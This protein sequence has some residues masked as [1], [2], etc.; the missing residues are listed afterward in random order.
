ML[1]IVADKRCTQ[2]THARLLQDELCHCVNSTNASDVASR[3]KNCL[4]DAQKH[5]IFQCIHRRCANADL[6]TEWGAKKAG[7]RCDSSV[8]AESVR[9]LIEDAPR[10]KTLAP[11]D[12]TKK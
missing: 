4:Q 11:I 9:T 1:S 10:A 12:R 8:T 7:S 5:S 2:A 6:L 3:V